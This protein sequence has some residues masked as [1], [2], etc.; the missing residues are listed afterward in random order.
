M[1]MSNLLCV[2]ETTKIEKIPVITDEQNE[3]NS[4]L[5]EKAKQEVDNS[6][7]NTDA[8]KRKKDELECALHD[9]NQRK[10]CRN[11]LVYELSGTDE[12]LKNYKNHADESINSESD[13]R[14]KAD[15]GI[16]RAW[17]SGVTEPEKESRAAI[18]YARIN[19]L[20]A[21]Q[22]ESNKKLHGEHVEYRNTINTKVLPNLKDELDSRCN[23]IEKNYLLGL[24]ICGP[25]DF[26]CLSSYGMTKDQTTEDFIEKFVKT[27]YDRAY[28]IIK[29]NNIP[30]TRDELVTIAVGNK[31]TK[32]IVEKINKNREEF[33]TAINPQPKP[34]E[35]KTDLIKDAA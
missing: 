34:E 5:Y 11:S 13:K 6:Q 20:A 28:E 30:V 22:L 9:Y 24:K 26:E 14:K 23:T 29:Q 16:D 1:I 18:A 25:T 19:D 32:D 4:Q 10:T 33:K 35:E 3:I 7:N 21:K 27:A 15:N 12:A 31:L 8:L 17:F 2:A